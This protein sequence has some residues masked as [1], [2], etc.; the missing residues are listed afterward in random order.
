MTAGRHRRA[1][2]NSTAQNSRAA[3]AKAVKSAVMLPRLWLAPLAVDQGTD[4]LRDHADMLLL[5]KDGRPQEV[6]WWDAQTLC[7]AYGPTIKYSKKLIEK[8][9]GEWGYDGLKLDGQHLN[10]VAPCYNPAHKHKRPEE[11]VEALQDYWK[12]VYDTALAINPDAVVELCPCGTSFAFHNSPYTN[13]VPSSDPLSSWQVRL[14]GKT[15]K[16]LMG[17]SAAFAGDHVELSTG[18][19]D[20]ASSVGIG[21]VV[22]TKFTWPAD[23]DKPLDKLPP[24]GYLLTPQKEK[25]WR[26]WI[27]LYRDK[28]LPTGNYLGGLYDIGFD[29]PETHVVEKDGALHFAFYADQWSGQ[30]EL[31]GLDKGSYTLTDMFTG[32]VIGKA[33]AKAPKISTK[34]KEFLLIEARPSEAQTA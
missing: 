10:G 34:F 6:T 3:F 12:M 20:F 16:A 29:R 26:K 21:A 9:I 33:S 1:T 13:Q 19:R 32:K 27:A 2:G 18:G 11:S 30:L 4:L 22:S 28:M 31:R 24:G 17:P 14:K 5:D 15:L 8:I 7:P 23:T 25:L